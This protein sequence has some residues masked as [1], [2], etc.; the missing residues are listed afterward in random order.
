MKYLKILMTLRLIKLIIGYFEFDDSSLLQKLYLINCGLLLSL[1]FLI[2][3]F[4]APLIYHSLP[5]AFQNGFRQFYGSLLWYSLLAGCFITRW[6]VLPILQ[7]ITP[8][9]ADIITPLT[10]YCHGV[11]EYLHYG[12]NFVNRSILL[13]TY[14]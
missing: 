2:I 12:T 8:L 9:V 3:K 14:S 11:L 5:C 4:T 7:M 1:I 13:G 10:G 6:L